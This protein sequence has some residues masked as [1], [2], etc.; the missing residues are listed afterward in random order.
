MKINRDAVDGELKLRL[1]TK[2]AFDMNAASCDNK[3]KIW[4]V[5]KVF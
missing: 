1:P 2:I 3:I 4:I 5:L